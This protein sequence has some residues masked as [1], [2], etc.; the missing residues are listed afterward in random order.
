[1][2]ES[3]GDFLST[4]K[5]RADV[6]SDRTYA[7]V[8]AQYPVALFSSPVP[9]TIQPS[10]SAIVPCVWHGDLPEDQDMAVVEFPQCPDD[11][12]DSRVS[13]L[14]GI[15]SG[16]EGDILLCIENDSSTDIVRAKSIY[17]CSNALLLRI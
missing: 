8:I 10:E 15:A 13:V 17:S 9:C 4:Y 16:A 1:M 3:G 11:P 2:L 7:D 14:P 12:C 6:I 5:E